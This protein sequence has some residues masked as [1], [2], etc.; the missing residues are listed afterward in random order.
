MFNFST[1]KTVITNPSQS[2]GIC[3]K[4]YPMVAPK[5]CDFSYHKT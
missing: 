3:R 4:I 5:S 2:L 1:G